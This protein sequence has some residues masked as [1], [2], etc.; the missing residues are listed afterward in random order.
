[1]HKTYH[2]E[3]DQRKYKYINKILTQNIVHN[4][5]GILCKNCHQINRNQDKHN[6]LETTCKVG[7]NIMLRIEELLRRDW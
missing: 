4:W 2:V 7:Q 3:F 5:K 6:P 1:M